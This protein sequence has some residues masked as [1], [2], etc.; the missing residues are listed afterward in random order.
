MPH[1]VVESYI[2]PSILCTAAKRANEP[3]SAYDSSK[4]ERTR[5]DNE[6]VLNIYSRDRLKQFLCYLSSTRDIEKSTLN[7]KN[8][9]QIFLDNESN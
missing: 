8:Q 6:Q 5:F 2:L 7:K 1:D 9:V 4:F 3:S